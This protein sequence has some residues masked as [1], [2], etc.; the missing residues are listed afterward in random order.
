MNYKEWTGDLEGNLPDIG[1]VA[2]GRVLLLDTPAK[3][4]AAE[5][6]KANLSELSDE[7]G[8]KRFHEQQQGEKTAAQDA[9]APVTDPQPDAAPS[10][11]GDSE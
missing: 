9:P 11:E 6:Y 8:E 2:K 5:L 10:T 4:E 7:E 3:L 1:H